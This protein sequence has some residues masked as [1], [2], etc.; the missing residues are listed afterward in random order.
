MKSSTVDMDFNF[1]KSVQT[2]RDTGHGELQRL[3]N[4][5]GSLTSRRKIEKAKRKAGLKRALERGVQVK[6]MP[7]MMQRAQLNKTRWDAE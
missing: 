5:G 1:L 7:Q 6:R 4:K 3:E 2:T